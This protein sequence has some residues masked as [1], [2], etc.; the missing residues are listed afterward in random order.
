[1]T[2]YRVTHRPIPLRPAREMTFTCLDWRPPHWIWWREDDAGE[3][4]H[5]RYDLAAEGEQT[6]FSQ[7]DEIESDIFPPLRPLLRIGVGHDVGV[8]LRC[9]RRVL[10]RT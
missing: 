4:L 8:Q 3:V 2:R 6:R 7:R 5:V 1:M 10:E 9:L